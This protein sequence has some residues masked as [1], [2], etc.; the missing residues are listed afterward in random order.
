MENF[1][2]D[3]PKAEEFEIDVRKKELYN[4]DFQSYS[5][6]PLQKEAS[7]VIADKVK[8]NLFAHV[9]ETE[10]L[11]KLIEDKKDVEYVAKLSEVAKEKLK[12]VGYPAFE[13]VKYESGKSVSFDAIVETFPEI[14]LKDF[15]GL[16]FKNGLFSK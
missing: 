5:L 14:K 16:S 10:L 9:S 12:T 1:E 3:I 8:S 4:Y 7:L 6:L 13:N 15:S 2:I 11:K